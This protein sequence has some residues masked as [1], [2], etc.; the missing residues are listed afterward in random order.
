MWVHLCKFWGAPNIPTSPCTR[1]KLPNSFF[2]LTLLFLILFHQQWCCWLK[3]VLI[4]TSPLFL[5]I[6]NHD[7][8]FIL[9]Y[10]W[11]QELWVVT[12]TPVGLRGCI[13]VPY[14]I[15]L[16]FFWREK[17]PNTKAPF[18]PLADHVL[19]VWHL[20]VCHAI[21]IFSNALYLSN[22]VHY[23]TYNFELNNNNYY[24]YYWKREKLT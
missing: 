7:Y 13:L 6:T 15:I 16:W 14:M 23:Y 20:H 5:V 11:L 19:Y 21:Q 10:E 3:A 22:V 1:E 2:A 9:N 24:Y 4:F 17:L 18:T 12:T 8:F